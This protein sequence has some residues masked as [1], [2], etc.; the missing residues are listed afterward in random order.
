MAPSALGWGAASCQA[1]LHLLAALWQ[2]SDVA[3]GA[4]TPGSG[5]SACA[6]WV[7]PHV[8]VRLM[9]SDVGLHL[10]SGGRMAAGSVHGLLTCSP[11]TGGIWVELFL[12]ALVCTHS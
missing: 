3:V 2:G 12:A 4:G 9:F 1:D 11:F 10:A 8:I 7:E 6:S 5:T